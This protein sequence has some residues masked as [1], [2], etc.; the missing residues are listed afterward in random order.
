MGGYNLKMGYF[1]L[2]NKKSHQKNLKGAKQ[3]GVITR[4]SLILQ[5]VHNLRKVVKQAKI[6]NKIQ[7]RKLIVF[8][9]NAKTKV[10]G[11]MIAVN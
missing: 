5:I 9:E 10:I 3:R 8:A 2:H 6:P 4:K 1:F 7:I 11:L